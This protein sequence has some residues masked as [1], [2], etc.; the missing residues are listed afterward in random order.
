MFAHKPKSALFKRDRSE[1]GQGN[2][3]YRVGREWLESRPEEKELEGA[4]G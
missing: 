2:P 3:K 1:V 4:G